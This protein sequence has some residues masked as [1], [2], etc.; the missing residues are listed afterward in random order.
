[1]P[2]TPSLTAL[3]LA[4][5]AE[6]V[7]LL[8]LLVNLATVH[9]GAVSSLC[10]PLHGSAYLAVL[11]LAWLSPETAA[12]GVRPRAFVPGIGG[13][14]VLAGVRRRSGTAGGVEGQ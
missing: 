2:T 14:L 10:G 9:A 8:A 7:T 1:V 11:A 5:H 13:L 12:P 3:R 4:A 6:A